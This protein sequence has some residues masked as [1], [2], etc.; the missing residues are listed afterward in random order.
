MVASFFWP[1]GGRRYLRDLHQAVQI[2]YCL[3]DIS[4]YN[5]YAKG[6]EG[7]LLDAAT[8]AIF[9][10]RRGETACVRPVP[11]HANWTSSGRYSAL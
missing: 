10:A 3:V 7:S 5:K 6:L 11:N 8:R 4:Q 9:L 2:I 1:G